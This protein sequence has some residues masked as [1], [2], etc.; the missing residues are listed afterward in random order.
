MHCSRCR[1]K[2]V[3]WFEFDVVL[4]KRAIED[5]LYTFKW[6]MIKQSEILLCWIHGVPGL[7]LPLWAFWEHFGKSLQLLCSTKG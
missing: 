4:H 7:A 3:Q 5:G 2:D 6:I 1:F